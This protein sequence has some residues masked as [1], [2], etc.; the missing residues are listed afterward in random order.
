MSLTMED[1]PAE[2]RLVAVVDE[3]FRQSYEFGVDLGEIDVVV[4]EAVGVRACSGEQA[5]AGRRTDG[6]LAIRTIK[7]Q[8]RGCEG[9]EV[10]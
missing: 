2:C 9:V 4:G 7:T 3:V 1:L 8:P 6:L 5:G 10:G